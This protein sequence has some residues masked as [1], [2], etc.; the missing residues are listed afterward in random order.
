MPCSSCTARL[1]A[2]RLTDLLLWHVQVA[3]LLAGSWRRRAQTQAT[4]NRSALSFCGTTRQLHLRPEH[5]QLWRAGLAVWLVLA[6][7]LL[8]LRAWQ[9]KSG[10][11]MRKRARADGAANGGGGGGWGPG[12]GL[13]SRGPAAAL[14]GAA[15]AAA[16]FVILLLAAGGS[17]RRRH[18][19][20][21]SGRRAP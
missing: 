13:G 8:A 16:L 1:A 17:A 18:S 9:Q 19:A 12:L 4:R 11:G 5:L 14:A 2:R 20:A 21:G 15:A 7:A 10:A 3:V 6:A